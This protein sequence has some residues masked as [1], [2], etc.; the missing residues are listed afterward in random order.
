MNTT[1]AAIT[2]RVW[3][4]WTPT[5]TCLWPSTWQSQ[6]ISVASQM[7]NYQPLTVQAA[8]PWPDHSVAP[9]PSPP[10]VTTLPFVVDPVVALPNGDGF[11]LIV[12]I[13]NA[14]TTPATPPL[15]AEPFVDVAALANWVSTSGN[16]G[17]LDTT[18]STVPAAI[19]LTSSVIGPPTAGM[20]EV[21]GEVTNV[22]TDATYNV[23]CQGPDYANSANILQT[24]VFGP[25]VSVMSMVNWP[26][27]FA[28][29]ISVT[30]F[31]GATPVPPNASVTPFIAMLAS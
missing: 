23:V 1:P 28:T 18:V 7:L 12:I 30:V 27:N 17:W 22:P 15:P 26:A 10:A 24:P 16:V 4:F 29:S 9:V 3:L 14:P 19:T 6:G 5:S 8:P 31:A 20:L 2:V 25:N 21:G 13:D 11:A